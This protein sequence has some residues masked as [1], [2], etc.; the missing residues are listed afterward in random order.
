MKDNS[1]IEALALLEHVRG[2]LKSD[3][4]S[5]L[6]RTELESIKRLLSQTINKLTD[7]GSDFSQISFYLLGAHDLIE[8]VLE[9]GDFDNTTTDTKA[10]LADH[11]QNALSMLYIKA[12]RYYYTDNQFD[13]YIGIDDLLQ[14]IIHACVK[15]GFYFGQA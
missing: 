3:T 9:D 15:S 14:R 12:G 4:R 2:S 8:T 5:Q 6:T 1:V 11:I 13:Y 7:K 10:M